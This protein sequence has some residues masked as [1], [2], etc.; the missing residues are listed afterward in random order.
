MQIF[1]EEIKNKMPD[2]PLKHK[3]AF[4]MRSSACACCKTNA[5][6]GQP[7]C[8]LSAQNKFYLRQKVILYKHR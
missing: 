8:F 5:F 2:S 4:S 1:T 6:V 7:R 3:E